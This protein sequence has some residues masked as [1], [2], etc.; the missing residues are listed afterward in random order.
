VPRLHSKSLGGMFGDRATAC[1]EIGPHILQSS[2]RVGYKSEARSSV[3]TFA[4]FRD[5][6]VFSYT[7][8]SSAIVITS[9][10]YINVM[11]MSPVAHDKTIINYYML[12][13]R[14][15]QTEKEKARCEKSMSLMERVTS[16]E[17][18][19]VSELGTIGV[20]TGAVERMILGGMEQDIVRFH[21]NIDRILA[22]G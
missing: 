12:V 2:G 9:P 22:G 19:W 15:P 7:V 21:R 20:A 18:L 8:I 10:T 13:D 11:L 4:E 17:D 14:M 6:G 5:M 3:N 16:E 1:V